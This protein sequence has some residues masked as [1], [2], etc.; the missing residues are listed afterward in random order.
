MNEAVLAAARWL[1]KSVVEDLMERLA[2]EVRSRFSGVRSP[3]RSRRYP[4][5]GPLD[6]AKTLRTNL[7]HYDPE[8]ARIYPEQLWFQE[9]RQKRLETWQI[10]LLVDQSGS[11]LSSTI[12]AAVTAAVLHGLPGIK[13]HLVVFDTEVVDLTDEVGDPVKTLMQVQLGG[14]TDIA[15]AVR[16]AA[17]LVRAPKRAI[18]VLITDF[19][20]GGEAA[21]LIQE[22]KALSGEGTLVLGLAALD[23][24]AD[25][26]YD[27][28]LAQ[29]LVQAGAEV[30][31]MTPGE[32]AQWLS[33][34]VRR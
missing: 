17:Q 26:A 2:Q 19:Y 18:V 30:G 14:G 16:Y 5:G 33:D 31:A 29:R 6:L 12:H 21:S 20:E 8:R 32:L 10:I 24:D 3:H 4:A 34:K 28:D 27:R 13:S 22:V 23:K 15:Q 11:M 7:R 1:V 9:R 25:P